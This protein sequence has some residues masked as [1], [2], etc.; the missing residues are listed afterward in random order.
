[1]FDFAAENTGCPEKNC[2]ALFALISLAAKMG[3]N[4]L[5]RW[6]PN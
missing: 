3:H 6:D 2:A 1:M 4:S 5:E